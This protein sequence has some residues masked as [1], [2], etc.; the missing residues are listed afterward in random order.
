MPKDLTADPN[1]SDAPR[2]FRY[3]LR[4]VKDY[5]ATLNEIRGEGAPE[6]N[7][8]RIMRGFLSP[9]IYPHVEEAG[10]YDAIVEL[11]HQI[12]I[13]RKNNVYA[14]HLLVSRK[15]AAGE[16][17]AEYLQALRLLA[18]EC[19]FQEVTAVFYR[20]ELI[21]DSFINGL[22]SPSIRQRLLET[23][24]I[25]LERAS[26]LAESLEQAHMQAPSM[27]QNTTTSLVASINQRNTFEKLGTDFDES[28]QTEDF[29]AVSYTSSPKPRKTQPKSKRLCY[30]CGGSFH[31]RNLCPARE[32]SCHICGKQEH[33][34]KVCRSSQ[35]QT[36]FKVSSSVTSTSD[37]QD[38]RYLVTVSKF[39]FAA[40]APN[41][42][43]RT[44]VNATISGHS[45][46]ALFDS[47]AS[48]NFINKSLEEQLEVQY[49]RLFQCHNGFYPA[50][51][52]NTRASAFEF[53]ST[54]TYVRKDRVE[55]NASSLCRRHFRPKVSK[56]A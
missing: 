9:E 21:C 14:R 54:R 22:T 8:T 2:V 10:Y 52:S 1:S 5:I 40:G 34:A 50:S 38:E 17:V 18:K 46:K 28:D 39:S 29:A 48:K 23:D 47:G 33:Y 32:R 44:V 11:L 15:Q 4:T 19:S 55:S 43:Q 51:S 45:V 42:L 31:P 53:G 49:V 30:Y 7:K 12:Y 37:A 20:E 6:V 16:N 41:C 24:N 36:A 13:K 25:N 3:W 56:C 27:G 26:Q 35:S